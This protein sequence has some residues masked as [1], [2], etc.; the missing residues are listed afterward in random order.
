MQKLINGLNAIVLLVFLFGIM[1]ISMLTVKLNQTV[2][3]KVLI[4]DSLILEQ[5]ALESRF[6]KFKEHYRHCMF[7]DKESVKIDR[8]GYIKI[9][10][11]ILRNSKTD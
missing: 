2:N 5:R 10:D 4:I 3:E 11:D 1:Y 8:L 6:E 9:K 7:L